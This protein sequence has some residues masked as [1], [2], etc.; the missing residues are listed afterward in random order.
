MKISRKRIRLFS[1]RCC[2]YVDDVDIEQEAIEV[3]A[4]PVEKLAILAAHRNAQFIS[5]M[6]ICDATGT[7]VDVHTVRKVHKG[8]GWIVYF[9]SRKKQKGGNNG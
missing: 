7:P 3:G 6:K 4:Q 2:V 9:R 8:K 5:I 1:V